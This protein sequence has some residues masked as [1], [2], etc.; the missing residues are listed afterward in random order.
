MRDTIK[1]FRLQHQIAP[2]VPL[3]SC[4]VHPHQSY[5]NWYRSWSSIAAMS[6]KSPKPTDSS[7]DE[8]KVKSSRLSSQ[9]RGR[10][11]SRHHY[12]SRIVERV[13]ERPSTNVA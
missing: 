9:R 11:R 8:K 6:S 10:S 5:N 4:Y 3:S 13:I 7:N 2:Y 1:R 12:G